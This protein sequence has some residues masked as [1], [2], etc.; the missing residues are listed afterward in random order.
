MKV[1]ILAGGLGTRIS[2]ETQNKPKPMVNIG[3]KPILWHIMNIQQSKGTMI[4]YLW[5]IQIKCTKR[6][7]SKLMSKIIFNYNGIKSSKK[8]SFKKL[9]NIWNVNLIDTGIMTYRR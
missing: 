8:Y 4:Y 1:V 5:R 2:E 6:F 7:F 3:G 9:K